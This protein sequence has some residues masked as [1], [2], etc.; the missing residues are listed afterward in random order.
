META[1]GVHHRLL[2]CRERIAYK[3][4]SF[5]LAYE[6]LVGHLCPQVIISISYGM[7]RRS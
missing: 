1:Y 5:S 2:N 4:K 7:Y 3:N 6:N